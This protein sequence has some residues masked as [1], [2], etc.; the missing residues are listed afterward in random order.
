MRSIAELWLTAAGHSLWEHL[1]GESIPWRKAA[2]DRYALSDPR[3]ETLLCG[4]LYF[5]PVEARHAGARVG[6]ESWHFR[7]EDAAAVWRGESRPDY[8]RHAR[9]EYILALDSIVDE[10]IAWHWQGRQ[11]PYYDAGP[12]EVALAL[13]SRIVRVAEARKHLQDAEKLLKSDAV[14]VLRARSG[15]TI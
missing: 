9:D 3:A 14:I 7:N 2:W 8:E 4:L 12:E 15:V 5:F 13:A 1:S 6:L 11:T 10:E